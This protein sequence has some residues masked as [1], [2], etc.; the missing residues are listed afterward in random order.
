[1]IY[2][3]RLLV[4]ILWSFILIA[5]DSKESSRTKLDSDDFIDRAERVNNLEQQI[6]SS[7]TII[8]SEFELFNVNGF[9]N[10][11]MTIPGASS[12]DYK[13]AIKI[14]TND[15]DKWLDGFEC[16]EKLDGNQIWMEEIIK[17]RKHNWIRKSKPE[18]FKRKNEN[19]ILILFRKEGVI[20]KRVITM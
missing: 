9:G 20:F 17:N 3:N 19:V 2:L 1:M 15:I 14:D 11:R 13:F 8:D 5:C 10:Q 7:S 6:K 18:Y 16:V 4:L 12:W